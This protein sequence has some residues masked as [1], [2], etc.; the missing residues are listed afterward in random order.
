M[1]AVTANRAKQP[2]CGACGQEGHIRRS[3][4]CPN[5]GEENRRG[6]TPA[7][8]EEH[9]ERV[10]EHGREKRAEAAQKIGRAPGSRGRP[11]LADAEREARR[12]ESKERHREKQ[13]EKQR[14]KAT[15][16]G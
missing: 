2:R 11:R 12:Q 3:K 7:Q 9:R 14:E 13:R 10:A 1:T 16:E 4:A 6:P 15:R 8:V 5:F